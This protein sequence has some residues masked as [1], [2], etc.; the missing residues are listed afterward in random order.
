MSSVR[1]W[2][3]PDSGPAAEHALISLLALNGLRV[4]EATGAD[5]QALGIERGHSSWPT[6]VAAVIWSRR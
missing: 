2:S 4:S 3:P 5:I 1:C 6:R